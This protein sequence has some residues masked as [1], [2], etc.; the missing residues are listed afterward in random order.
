MGESATAIGSGRAV[1]PMPASPRRPRPTAR[2]GSWPGVLR[3]ERLHRDCLTAALGGRHA[4]WLCAPSALAS[5]PDRGRWESHADREPSPST[6]SRAAAA[7]PAACLPAVWQSAALGGR[8]AAW[9]R[10]PSALASP[11]DRGRWEPHADRE[12]SPSIPSR[13][14]AARPAA[15]LP[16]VGLVAEVPSKFARAG[17]GRPDFGPEKSKKTHKN[18]S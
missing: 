12:P 14:T 13:A 4:A 7:R 5:P 6:P 10:A 18:P 2:S 17:G 11:P 8:H 16:A 3:V 9:L 1:C 15:C